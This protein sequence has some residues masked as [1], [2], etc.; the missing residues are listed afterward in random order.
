MKFWDSSALVPLLVQEPRTAYCLEA[1]NKD[2]EMLL[3]CLSRL[4]VIS[5]LCRKLR[6]EAIKNDEFQEAKQLLSKY[7]DHAYEVTSI[8]RVKNRAARLLEVH[9]LRAADACQ[10]AA[11]L[12]AT[13]EDPSRLELFCFD[14]RLVK[15]ALKEGFVVNP[16]DRWG[17]G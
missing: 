15:A 12:V 8:D 2:R 13:Q 7:V 17:R 11:A 9:P 14:E 5:A 1:V 6:E 10:L 16:G 3:W 4:E